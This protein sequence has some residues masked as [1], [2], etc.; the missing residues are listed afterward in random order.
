MIKNTPINYNKHDSLGRCVMY[1][2]I[3]ASNKEAIEFYIA[4]GISINKRT[5]KLLYK[6]LYYYHKNDPIFINVIQQAFIKKQINNKIIN[7]IVES[8]GFYPDINDT[9]KS[10]I[11][12][13]FE[14]IKNED[15]IVNY[16]KLN[17]IGFG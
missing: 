15:Y 17:K 16:L 12:I 10:Y 4:S 5:K 14:Y 11:D 7:K 8:Y 1:T 2:S 13:V 6:S 3:I 9:I